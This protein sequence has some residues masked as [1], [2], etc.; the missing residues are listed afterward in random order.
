MSLPGRSRR[1]LCSR[2]LGISI[3]GADLFALSGWLETFR[4]VAGSL[5]YQLT[6][7]DDSDDARLPWAE[8]RPALTQRPR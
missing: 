8:D 4:E 7:E 5:E 3:T 1:P 6:V 2:R